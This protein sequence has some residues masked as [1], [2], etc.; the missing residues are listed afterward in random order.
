MASSFDDRARTWDDDPAKVERAGQVAGTIRSHVPVD[1][2]SRVL[3]Y[4]AGTGL[5]AQALVD[6]VGPLTLVDSSVGMRE[7]MEGKVASGALPEGTRIWDVDLATDE[8]PRERFDLIV[9]VMALHHIPDL[10]P[11][12]RRFAAL[13]DAGGHLCIVDLEAD[14]GWYHRDKPD[15]DG[16]DGFEHDVLADALR[17]AG[18]HDISFAPC[19]EMRKKGR[20]YP[21]FL[22]VATPRSGATGA[23]PQSGA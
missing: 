6:H 19:N 22:A 7:V 12:L 14:D 20:S 3:E 16:H 1:R 18:F 8:P 2:R 11:V 5:V 4:G 15:F 9:T 21:L 13:L 10:D 23:V 17:A